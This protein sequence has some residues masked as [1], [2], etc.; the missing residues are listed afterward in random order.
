M[1]LDLSEAALLDPAAALF[2]ADQFRGGIRL[3]N[4]PVYIW[5]WIVRESGVESKENANE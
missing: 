1:I 3:V 5:R 4:C 2:F